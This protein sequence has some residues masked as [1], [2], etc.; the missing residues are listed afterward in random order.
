MPRVQLCIRRHIHVP[1]RE[2]RTVTYVTGARPWQPALSGTENLQGVSADVIFRDQISTNCATAE[3]DNGNPAVAERQRAALFQ[4]LEKFVRGLARD[5]E[6]RSDPLWVR[7]T[8]R[9]DCASPFASRAASSRLASRS[10]AGKERIIPAYCTAVR[11]RSPRRRATS[12]K[13]L[14]SSRLICSKARDAMWS[15][16]DAPKLT[17][18][19]GRGPPSTVESSPTSYPA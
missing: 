15:T 9:S 12:L 11:C 4:R 8:V 3:I 19:C 17:A 18:S 5:A 14:G 7:L 10:F 1:A 6:R 13:I 16:F 2:R